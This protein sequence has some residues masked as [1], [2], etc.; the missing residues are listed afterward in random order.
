MFTEEFTVTNKL[1]V[2]VNSGISLTP[3]TSSILTIS[4]G[5]LHIWKTTTTVINMTARRNSFFSWWESVD[6]RAFDL[7]LELIQFYNNYLPF[8]WQNIKII[9]SKS[10]F[11]V[12]Y[13]FVFFEDDMKILNLLNLNASRKLIRT[14]PRVI[15]KGYSLFMVI[16]TEGPRSSTF[17][18]S[19]YIRRFNTER[20]PNG[21]TNIKTKYIHVT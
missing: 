2:C 15:F 3:L 8:Q 20:Q 5:I 11:K 13:I 1:D 18:T 7:L 19:K 10:R 4:G 6:C 12:K 16:E 21:R 14:L 9:R 17:L